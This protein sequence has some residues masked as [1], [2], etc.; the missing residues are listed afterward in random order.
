MARLLLDSHRPSEALAALD[1][2]DDAWTKEGVI[3]Y[4]ARLLRGKT[5]A[6]LDRP[7]QAVRAFQSALEIVPSAQSP[8]I[9]IMVIEAKRGRAPIAEA[10]SRDIRT[11]ADTVNDPWWIYAHGDV[12]FFP[13]WDK[14]LRELAGK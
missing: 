10:I 6:A 12:R 4:W 5:L 3:L 1:R 7:D 9:G 14:T 13:Q 2:F 11:A 8:R